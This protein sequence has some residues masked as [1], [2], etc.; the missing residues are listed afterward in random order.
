LYVA[1]PDAETFYAADFFFDPSEVKAEMA[2]VQAVYTS[3]IMPIYDGVVD[4]DEKIDAAL[5]K[6]RAA[7][8]DKVIAEYQRQLDAYKASKGL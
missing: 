2:N 6:L 3:D 4:Y 7:G 5:Q 8:I 1:D